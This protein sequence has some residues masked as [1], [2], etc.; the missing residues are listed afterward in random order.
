M[1]R[2]MI[3]HLQQGRLGDYEMLRSQTAQLMQSP[4]E[5]GLPG[6]STMAHGF[7]HEKRNGHIV[8]GHGGDTV[9]FHTEFDLLPEEGVGIFYNFNSRGREDAVYGLRKMLFDG[10]MDRYFPKSAAPPD[11]PTLATA[12]SDAQ[13]I[14]E[15]Y[16]SSRRV[17]HGFLSVFYLLQQSVITANSD[18][19]IRTARG[20][21]GHLSRG[22]P[23]PLVSD[24]RR[25]GAL[26]SRVVAFEEATDYRLSNAL[27][28]ELAHR[29]ARRTEQ[30]EML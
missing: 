17:E 25:H 2:F 9:M 20:R 24:E 22:G 6:F 13:T 28:I 3:A 16:Q 10:F 27:V 19:T 5:T 12:S 18:G 1:A 14:A 7:F 21:R 29:S 4:S 15:R 8:I 26:E 23:G 30:S 11:L